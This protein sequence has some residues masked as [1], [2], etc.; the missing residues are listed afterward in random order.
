MNSEVLGLITARGGSK[1][2]S[3]NYTVYKAW[4]YE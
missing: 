3:E 4:D 1:T 2:A